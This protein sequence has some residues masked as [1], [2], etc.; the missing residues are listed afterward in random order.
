M[1]ERVRQADGVVRVLAG[2]GYVRVGIPAR[3]VL[4]DL[5]ARVTLPRIVES[6]LRGARRKTDRDC[7]ADRCRS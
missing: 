6:V 1:E 7:V 3:I 5:K 4:L 2:D